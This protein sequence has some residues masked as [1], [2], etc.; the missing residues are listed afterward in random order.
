LPCKI[1]KFYIFSV[2]VC[3]LRLP[4]TQCACVIPS[5]VACLALQYFSTLSHKRHDFIFT[6]RTLL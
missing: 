6:K 3:S 2:C 4:G 5:S 1:N